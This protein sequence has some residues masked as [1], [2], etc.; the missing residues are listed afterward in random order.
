MQQGENLPPQSHRLLE[1]T[2]VVE[3][4]MLELKAATA[5]QDIVTAQRTAAI[6]SPLVLVT[7]KLRGFFDACG[8]A[9]RLLFR[10][11]NFAREYLEQIDAL[12]PPATGQAAPR[13]PGFVNQ[14]PGR[15]GVLD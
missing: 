5:T 11:G 1:V 8:L 14:D 3:N 2:A 10:R 15:G 12:A 7:A 4:H 13:R 9:V 6:G